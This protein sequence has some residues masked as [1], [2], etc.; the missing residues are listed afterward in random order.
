MQRHDPRLRAPRAHTT[1][2]AGRHGAPAAH[3][4]HDPFRSATHGP[5]RRDYALNRFLHLT[6]K[7]RR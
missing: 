7:F 6:A 4:G 2:A 3:H 1:T 5:M